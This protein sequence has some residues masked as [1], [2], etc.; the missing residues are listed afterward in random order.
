MKN[1][2]QVGKELHLCIEAEIAKEIKELKKREKE[3]EDLIDTLSELTY[4]RIDQDSTSLCDLFCEDN[5]RRSNA[6][7]KYEGLSKVLNLSNLNNSCQ[8]VLNRNYYLSRL[9]DYSE[10]AENDKIYYFSEFS[11]SLITLDPSTMQETEKVIEG[12]LGASV[13]CILPYGNLLCYV[14]LLSKRTYFKLDVIDGIVTFLE[15]PNEQIDQMNALVGNKFVRFTRKSNYSPSYALLDLTTMEW[16]NKNHPIVLGMQGFDYLI[17]F[18]GK[19]YGTEPNSPYVYVRLNNYQFTKGYRLE[20]GRKMLF[21]HRNK[22]FLLAQ[23]SKTLY[24]MESGSKRFVQLKTYDSDPGILD[25]IYI[26]ELTNSVCF[27]LNDKSII[28]FDPE[29][30]EFTTLQLNQART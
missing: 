6:L 11:S 18:G 3:I 19:I 30:Y 27:Y 10:I 9:G 2:V 8:R 21:A 16:C 17:R 13:K 7:S 25:P 23:N 12:V 1:L 20:N 15:Q 4:V 29:T 22:L 5:A 24:C 26:K 14:D 28:K